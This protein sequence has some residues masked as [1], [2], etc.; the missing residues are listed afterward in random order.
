MKFQII[1]IGSIIAIN[2]IIDSFTLLLLLAGNLDDGEKL[3]FIQYYCKIT[4]V[5]LSDKESL[6]PPSAPVSLCLHVFAF[7]VNYRWY[8]RVDIISGKWH[9]RVF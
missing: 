3:W 6:V 5:T 4:N 1:K 9:L 8:F 2:I 7:C